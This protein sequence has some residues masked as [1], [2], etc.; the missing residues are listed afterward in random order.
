M[1]IH[2]LAYPFCYCFYVHFCRRHDKRNRHACYHEGVP[3]VEE[4]CFICSSSARLST[5]WIAASFIREKHSVILSVL[6]HG[7]LARAF[8]ALCV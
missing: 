3:K 4:S 7:C 6:C 5:I 1:V 8:F 2:L